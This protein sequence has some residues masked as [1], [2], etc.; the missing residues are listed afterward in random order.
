MHRLLMIALVFLTLPTASQAAQ[1]SLTQDADYG[2]L[3]ALEGQIAEGDSDRL[4]ALLR[5][6]ASLPRYANTIYVNEDP[7][8][9]TPNV[10]IYEPMNLCLDS[11]GGALT[12][13]MALTRLVHGTLGT[14]IRAGARCESACALV[15]MAGSHST[16]TDF[17]VSVNRFLHVDG[18]LGFHAPSL[19][20]PEGRYD[21]A[22]VARAYEISVAVSELIFRN[23][24]T[25]RFAPSLA[26]RMHATPATDMHYVTRV[27]E[28]ARWDIGI[29]GIAPPTRISDAAI[30]NGCNNLYLKVQDQMT[31]DPDAWSRGG[32]PFEAVRRTDT[33]F[34]YT[35]F[36][37]EAAGTCTGGSATSGPDAGLVEGF[38][39]DARLIRQSVWAVGGVRDAQPPVFFGFFQNYMAWPGEMPLSALPRDGRVP[40]YQSAT[41]RCYVFTGEPAVKSDDEPCLRQRLAAADGR[42]I[43]TFEW[44]S[45]AQT[46]L[47]QAGGALA[48]NGATAIPW[49]W[50]G[51]AQPGDA[52]PR[53]YRNEVSQNVFCF[54][55][56]G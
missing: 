16:E 45:G 36:G 27:E 19:T 42:M 7:A 14:V 50:P 4:L 3:I 10:A 1:L 15:F 23:L 37:M 25:Y 49:Y 35:A 26:A 18:R 2:C 43:D 32:L 33:G 8:G 46:R 28:A 12:E 20:V 52:P 51:A 9:G 5:Q 48:I 34:S 47:E 21:A 11:P 40:D 38:W 24:V 13:A 44:P 17:G 6:A 56:D 30:R 29:L 39:G 22:T 55:R 54:A 31:S 41:G 53:C